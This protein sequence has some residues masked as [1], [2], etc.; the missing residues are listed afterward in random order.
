ME[1]HDETQEWTTVSAATTVLSME[2]ASQNK[3]KKSHNF[4][5]AVLLK[6]HGFC[7]GDTAH[8]LMGNHLLTFPACFGCWILGGVPSLG[9]VDLD[10]KEVAKQ[11][12]QLFL[13]KD[14]SSLHVFQ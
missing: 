11:V 5:L 6:N 14:V 3:E 1:L 9:D 2:C 12:D 13:Q 7:S 4:R 8:L 10:A